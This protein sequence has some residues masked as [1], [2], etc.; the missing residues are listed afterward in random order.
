MLLVAIKSACPL[1]YS[2]HVHIL[3]ILFTTAMF[4]CAKL[5]D[6]TFTSSTICF[7]LHFQLIEIVPTYIDKLISLVLSYTLHPF[8]KYCLLSPPYL[9]SPHAYKQACE[10]ASKQVSITQ[11]RY[12]TLSFKSDLSLWEVNEYTKRHKQAQYTT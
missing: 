5:L 1:L 11:I 12:S 2:F 8:Y 4:S 3:H 7:Y 9:D 10:Q 6:R